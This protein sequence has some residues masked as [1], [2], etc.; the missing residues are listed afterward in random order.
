MIPVVNFINILQAAFAPIFLHQKLQNQTV[1]IEKLRKVFS[2]EKG[3]NK[4]LM[5]LIPDGILKTCSKYCAGGLRMIGNAE[6]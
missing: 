2:N 3:A 6:I 4:M 5:K 1:I